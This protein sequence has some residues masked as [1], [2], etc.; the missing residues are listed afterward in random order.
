MADI[1]LVPLEDVKEALGI[2]T[3]TKNDELERILKSVSMDF[4]N[5]SGR[6]V[7]LI[8][9]TEY[10]DVED[11]TRQIFLKGFPVEASPA[12][13]LRQDLDRN[14]GDTTIVDTEYYYTDN[15]TG[16]IDLFQNYPAGRKTIKITY[17]GGMAK[18]TSPDA[19][20]EFWTLYPEVANAVLQQVIAEYKGI[21]NLG[22]SAV[23]IRDNQVTV[24]KP[25]GRLPI[26][27]RAIIGAGR[28][29]I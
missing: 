2:T 5:T 6:G 18:M 22:A 10:F 17:T 19:G 16:I 29:K 23:K 4:Q 20:E 11:Y 9:R 7:D 15:D 14:F 8:A 27:Q 12:L 1:I 21:P 24:N 28:I 3:E 26:F 13:V 25:V